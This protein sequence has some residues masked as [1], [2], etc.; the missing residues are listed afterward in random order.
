MCYVVGAAFALYCVN[1]LL[2][3][4]LQQWLRHGN[5]INNYWHSGSLANF[6][7][8]CGLCTDLVVEFILQFTSE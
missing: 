5:Q 2:L 8:Y 7:Q 6:K 1:H 4:K 3:P